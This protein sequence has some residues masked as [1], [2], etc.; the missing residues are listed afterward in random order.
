[1]QAQNRSFDIF[2]LQQ[3][4]GLRFNR[5]ALLNAGMLL[6]SGSQYDH[7]CFHDVDTL[8]TLQ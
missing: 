6:L 8:P 5:G 7:F 1:M 2:I 3:S 4:P